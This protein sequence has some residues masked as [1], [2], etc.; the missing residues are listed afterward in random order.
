MAQSAEYW[1]EAWKKKDERKLEIQQRWECWEWCLVWKRNEEK[2]RKS[3]EAQQWLTW[4]WLL[5]DV[6]SVGMVIYWEIMRRKYRGRRGESSLIKWKRSR[7]RQLNTG[8][9]DWERDWRNWDLKNKMPST[10]KNG[11]KESWSPIPTM[12]QG[13]G[14]EEDS[15]MQF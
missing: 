2:M 11:D 12:G 9:T 1:R 13:V 6:N 4:W 15:N 14:E 10:Y 8:K 7:G 5:N 3:G